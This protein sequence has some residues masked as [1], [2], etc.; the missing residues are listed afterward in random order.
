[1]K[2]YD[3]TYRFPTGF[4]IASKLLDISNRSLDIPFDVP[5]REILI[6]LQLKCHR[7]FAA[8]ILLLKSGYCIEAQSHI[9]SILETLFTTKYLLLDIDK[10][11]EMFLNFEVIER[12]KMAEDYANA[13]KVYHEKRLSTQELTKEEELEAKKEYEDALETVLRIKPEFEK[14]SAIRKQWATELKAKKEKYVMDSWSLKNNYDMACATGLEFYFLLAFKEFSNLV[15]P[16]TLSGNKYRTKTTGLIIDPSPLGIRRDLMG[17][18]VTHMMMTQ[19]IAQLY[20]FEGVNE[21]LEELFSEINEL[22]NT[23]EFRESDPIFGTT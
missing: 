15:H 20:E 8:S 22:R 4:K 14:A 12:F 11:K 21:E 18:C 19:A 3:F 17:V 9:R 16:S 10:H 23:Q 5:L 7:L 13:V 6:T 1:M 2:N